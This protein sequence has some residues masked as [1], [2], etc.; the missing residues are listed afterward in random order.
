MLVAADV[1][2]PA[3]IAQLETIGKQLNIPVYSDRVSKNP[4]EIAKAAMAEAASKLYDIVI[5]DTAGRLHVN[6][7]LMEELQSLTGLASVKEKVQKMIDEL[8]EALKW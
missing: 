8:G 1:Q 5:I 4:V 2:R 7:E 6:E 3:A